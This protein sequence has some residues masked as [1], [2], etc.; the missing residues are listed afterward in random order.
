MSNEGNIES[1]L[2]QLNLI[3]KKEAKLIQEQL[4]SKSN[5]N[6][7]ESTIFN[8]PI[9]FYGDPPK[10]TK[11]DAT[12]AALRAKKGIYVFTLKKDV[13][14]TK[15]FNKVPY[16]AQ[17]KDISKLN[18]SKGEILY[19]GKTKSFLTRMHQHFA[20]PSELN[21]TGSLKLGAEY[22]KALINNLTIYAFSLKKDYIKFYDIIASTV[23]AELHLILKPLVGNARV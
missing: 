20:E 1:I 15:D 22:R 16:G 3:L 18:F 14:I 23:E 9:V 5:K 7:N 8:A 19:V 6:V 13:A 17:L 21:K 10:N 11:N 4:L 2:E 12:Y